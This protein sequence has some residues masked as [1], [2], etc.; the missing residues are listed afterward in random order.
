MHPLDTAYRSNG[1]T[2]RK[3]GPYGENLAQGYSDIS[4]SIDAWGNER[5]DYDFS[6]GDFSESTGHFTQ[7]VWKAS[8]TVGCGRKFC[9]GQNNVNGW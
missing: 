8:S 3:G 5:R 9:N 4:R 2:A 6:R 1:L 7:L